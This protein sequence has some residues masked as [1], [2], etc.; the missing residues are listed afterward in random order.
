MLV[1]ELISL[2]K[3]RIVMHL[4]KTILGS[5]TLV[6]QVAI[7]MPPTGATE[8]VGGTADIVLELSFLESEGI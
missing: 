3:F 1:I 7:L 8:S 6:V 5:L 4:R 2:G